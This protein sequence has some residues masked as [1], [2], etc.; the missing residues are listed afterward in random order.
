MKAAGAKL[1]LDLLAQASLALL[2]VVGDGAQRRIIQPVLAHGLPWRRPI[3]GRLRGE[4]GEHR[5]ELLAAIKSVRL[6]EL[7]QVP[8]ILQAR[9][10]VRGLETLT[11]LLAVEIERLRELPGELG[12][13]GGACDGEA[14]AT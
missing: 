4:L 1:G 6:V 10:D 5:A 12:I 13:F 8:S 9:Q 11:E 7:R 14:R 3:R 2:P